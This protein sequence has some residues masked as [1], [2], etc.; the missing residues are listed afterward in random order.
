LVGR[1][2][3][4]HVDEGDRRARRLELEPKVLTGRP[5]RTAIRERDAGAPGAR[6]S[7]REAQPPSSS[8]TSKAGCA[9]SAAA[10]PFALEDD[11]VE[12]PA[13]DA[14]GFEELHEASTPARRT[15][16]TMLRT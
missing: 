12:A 6:R 3:R 14:D 5:G 9:V 4:G 15:I 8:T 13:P 10:V 16:I 11:D 1:R 7:F 2:T